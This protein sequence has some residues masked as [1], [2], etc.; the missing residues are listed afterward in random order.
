MIKRLKEA[1]KRW[2]ERNII[3][4]YPYKDEL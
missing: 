1:F 4:E 2:W 3:A